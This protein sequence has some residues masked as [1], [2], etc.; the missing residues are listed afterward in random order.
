MKKVRP[1]ITWMVALVVM[2]FTAMHPKMLLAGIFVT[3]W[4]CW[5]YLPVAFGLFVSVIAAFFAGK[6]SW[7]F[8]ICLLGGIIIAIVLFVRGPKDRPNFGPPKDIAQ[9]YN[10]AAWMMGWNWRVGWAC[11]GV[12]AVIGLIAKAGNKRLQGKS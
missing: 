3:L 12:G 9:S 11:I 10:A 8:Q 7:P 1:W 2:T 4:L 6:R 5:F